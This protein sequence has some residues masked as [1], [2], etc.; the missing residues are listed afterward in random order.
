MVIA[1]LKIKCW[2][3]GREEEVVEILKDG[4]IDFNFDKPCPICRGHWM[5]KKELTLSSVQP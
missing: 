5:T 1:E 2:N 3:C 4:T